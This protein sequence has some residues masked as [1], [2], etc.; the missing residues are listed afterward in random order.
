MQGS[1][2]L[3]VSLNIGESHVPTPWVDFVIFS[4]FL[5]LFYFILLIYFLFFDVLPFTFCQIFCKFGLSVYSISGKS[6]YE[7]IRYS[8]GFQSLPTPLFI[9]MKKN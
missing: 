2:T 7:T 4:I 6:T 9:V 8:R 1:L 5:T 3:V